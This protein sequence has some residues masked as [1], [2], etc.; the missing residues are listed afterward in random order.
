MR[1]S[2]REASGWADRW[3]SRQDLHALHPDDFRLLGN[4]FASG[5]KVLQTQCD[6]VFYVLYDLFIGLALGV[7]SLEG[8]TFG[9]VTARFILLHDNLEYVFTFH[10][11]AP[12]GA[13]LT[14]Q[15]DIGVYPSEG[16]L[17]RPQSASRLVK[18]NAAQKHA[19]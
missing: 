17:F 6:Y 11:Y 12:F 16:K 2:I 10:V 15:V 4:S 3:N 13:A 18:A 19:H 14:H 8:W 5:F 9:D 7:A 1:E